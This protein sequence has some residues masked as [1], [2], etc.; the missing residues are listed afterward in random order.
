M[1]LRGK[2]IAAAGAAVPTVTK[3][4]WRA[5]LRKL[6]ERPRDMEPLSLLRGSLAWL[7]D[8]QIAGQASAKSVIW[9]GCAG[10]RWSAKRPSTG[11][12]DQLSDDRI[13]RQQ[14][15]VDVDGQ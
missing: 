15:V 2:K 7:R 13:N 6:S 10:I 3:G 9:V 11:L 14:T 8:R 12:S 1:P 5:R 4:I